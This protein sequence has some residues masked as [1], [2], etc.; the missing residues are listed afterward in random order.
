MP[1]V[2]ELIGHP[3][4]WR[5]LALLA[6]SD[7]RVGEL[8]GALGLAQSGVSYHLGKLR[9]AGLVSRHRSDADGRDSYYAANLD[10]VSELIG[11]AAGRLHPALRPMRSLA[12]V[13]RR[14][15]VLFICTGNSARSQMAEALAADLGGPLVVAFSAGSHPKQVSPLAVKVLAGRGIDIASA[16]PKHLRQF[17]ADDFDY[18][19][20]LCD[21]VREV[22][23]EFPGHPLT[24]HW[25]VPDPARV[26]GGEEARQAALERTA[27]EI[28]IRVL[29]LLALIS[30]RAVAA[31]QDEVA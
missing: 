27:E 26:V 13:S 20:T 16:Q 15:R 3:V 12:P 22:C 23:P 4:R 8:S 5:L 18:V 21:R 6:L 17:V 14:A 24:F 10:R 7:R 11:S 31:E 19:V 30:E 2:F 25:S 29:H 28:T 9:S 1:A